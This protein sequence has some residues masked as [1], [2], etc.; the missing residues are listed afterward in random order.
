MDLLNWNMQDQDFL[1]KEIE[2]LDAEVA[3]ARETILK[4]KNSEV[5]REA[6]ALEILK[7]KLT[8]WTEM[9]G[10]LLNILIQQLKSNQ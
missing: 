2:L 3:K 1:R 6:K 10:V 4:V 9:R 8:D 5:T 7:T